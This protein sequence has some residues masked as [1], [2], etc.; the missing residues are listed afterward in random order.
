MSSPLPPAA[1]EASESAAAEA[2]AH[3]R[4]LERRIVWIWGNAVV[5][6][7][8]LTAALVSFSVAFLGLSLAVRALI[9]LV[10]LFTAHMLYQHYRL[11]KTQ[12]SLA[13]HQ[14]Q[15]EV[16]RRMA[17]VDQLTGLYNRRFAEQRLA[18][19]IARSERRGH[20][21]IVVLL[22]L[23]NFKHINDNYGHAAGD[24]A[25]KSFAELLSRSTRG[26]DLAVRWG[27]DEFM[28]LL[29]D[30]ELDQLSRVLVRLDNFK[31]DLAG[32]PFPLRF[33]VGW[34]AYQPGDKFD[35]LLEAAD[36]KLYANKA[37]AKEPRHPLPAA[38]RV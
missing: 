22:D 6:I 1:G 14:I 4:E 11:R 25:L 29:L 19:E 38:A 5:V 7:L 35:E 21:L 3:L 32:K 20:S 33:S 24:F 28:L 8:C 13:E 30:C 37:L 31:I 23:D 12:R 36:R 10:L 16:F 2:R 9:G 18:A 15:A 17:I 26:S 34:S 27:G